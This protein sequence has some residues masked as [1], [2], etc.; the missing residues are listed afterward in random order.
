[1]I[2]KLLLHPRTFLIAKNGVVPALLVNNVEVLGKNNLDEYVY[3]KIQKIG[4]TEGKTIEILTEKRLFHI[5]DSYHVYTSK[6]KPSVSQIKEEDKILNVRYSESAET[7]D[8][9]KSSINYPNSYKSYLCGFQ[10]SILA[11]FFHD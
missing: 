10:N 8:L 4:E 1:M 6:G 7:N 3:K 9:L 2:T 5:H 11:K